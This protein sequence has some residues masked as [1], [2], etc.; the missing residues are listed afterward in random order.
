[1]VRLMAQTGQ[2]GFLSAAIRA[3]AR[4]DGAH[5][6]G[7][8]L[9]IVVLLATIG[10][11]FATARPRIVRPAVY[12]AVALCFA[13]WIFVQDLGFFGGVG[14]DPNSMLPM[15]VVF[16]SAY[17]AVV[18]VPV[19]AEV[20][21]MTPGAVPAEVATPGPA[22]GRP[23]WDRLAPGYLAQ[24]LAAVAAL[25][26]VLVGAV[27][28]ISAAINPVADP[29]LAVAVDGTPNTV[30]LPA[31]P[32]RL[33]DQEGRAV[34]MSDLRGRTVALTFLD[35]VCTS[36]CPLIAREFREADAMLGGDAS[37][38]VFVAVV[39]NEIYRSTVF[40]N[41]FD[42]QEGLEHMRNWLYLTGSLSE[43]RQVWDHYGIAAY[44]VPAGAMVAHGDIAYLID[45][46]GQTRLI[47]STDPGE[48][49]SSSM[50]SFSG[51]LA[52]AIER[53]VHA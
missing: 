8:N 7:V 12:V 18:H 16:V 51:Y 14:T 31:P 47:V 33:V 44:V 21:L 15:A 52:T 40:T 4:L 42:R 45:P 27:P 43:L 38:V 19:A 24:A 23:W 49:S 5:G 46:R 41:A 53:L 39:A 48:G 13:D 37:R 20:P 50:S 6:W 1:M 29:I 11:A 3:F 35:P 2:P 30:D 17:L 34:T 9:V 36:D 10:L 26:V 28:L 25:V 32:F 22:D